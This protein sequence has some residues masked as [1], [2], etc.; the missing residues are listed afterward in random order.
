[1]E[2]KTRIVNATG[3]VLTIHIDTVQDISMT[4]EMIADF[5]RVLGADH[6][7]WAG[8]E[9]FVSFGPAGWEFHIEAAR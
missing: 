5:D 9:L 1:M 2:T 7:K 4:P 3:D 8:E 6:D